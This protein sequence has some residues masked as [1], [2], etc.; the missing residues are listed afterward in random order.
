MNQLSVLLLRHPKAS[1]H[2]HEAFA[3]KGFEVIHAPTLAIESL[4]DHAQ[5]RTDLAA[6][7]AC[8]TVVFTSPN[9]VIHAA[10]LM[11]LTGLPTS[12]WAIGS[13]TQQALSDHGCPHANTGDTAHSESMLAAMWSSFSTPPSA[14]G[15]VTAPNGRGL[16]DA[17]IKAHGITL[18]RADV[19]RRVPQ[20]VPQSTWLDVTLAA[21]SQTLVTLLTS[22][23]AW[24]ALVAQTT[25]ALQQAITSQ[26]VVVSSERLVH[27]A[28]DA[29][30]DRQRTHNTQS[31]TPEKLADAAFQA[32]RMR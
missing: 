12:V 13:A 9:A 22:E 4:S 10:Q 8:S 14:I 19:Y 18:Q 26:P 23:Q 21:E 6:A 25:H 32:I 17:D 3:A 28:V 31:M 16:I 2:L 30:F 27:A 20:Q 24:A 7:L 5:T 1:N 11:P 15:L 29:G